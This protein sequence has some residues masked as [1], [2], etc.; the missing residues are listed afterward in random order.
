MDLGETGREFSAGIHKQGRSGEKS[1]SLWEKEKVNLVRRQW[2]VT[3]SV[4]G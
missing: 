2:D 1:W 4:V 3:P